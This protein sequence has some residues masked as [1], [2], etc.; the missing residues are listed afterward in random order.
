MTKTMSMGQARPHARATEHISPSPCPT[1]GPMS[2]A[3]KIAQKGRFDA[4]ICDIDGC[5]SPESSAPMNTAALCELAERNRQA[6]QTGSGPI[7]T[8]CTGRP[9]PFAEAMCRM[10]GNDVLP[11]MAENG[12][13][14]YH[15]DHNVYDRD[16]SITVEHLDAIAEAQRWV[17]TE[18]GPLGVVMQPGKS[19]SISL[20][21]EDTTFLRSLQSRVKDECAI[22]RWPLRVSMTWLY[23]NCDLKHISKATALVRFMK[24]TGLV[25]RRLAGIGDTLSDLAIRECVGWF[26]CPANADAQLKEH[27]DYVSPKPQTEGTLDILDQLVQI[28]DAS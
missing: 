21:H 10:I 2:N 27:A 13:W 18:L 8:L 15:P 11:I 3:K 19:A 5:L 23:I 17:E 12:V 24:H 16:P 4:V 14:M 6:I 9:L 22:R 28:K 1:L 20:Y 25:R 26:G 7:V